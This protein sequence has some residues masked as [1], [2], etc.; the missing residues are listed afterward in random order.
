MTSDS[1]EVILK[2]DIHLTWDKENMMFLDTY[3]NNHMIGNKNWF[4]ELDESVIRFIRFANNS[5]VALKGM[6]NILVKR[7]DGK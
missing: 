5:M 1:E 4:I 7:E 6:G 3:C 2:F